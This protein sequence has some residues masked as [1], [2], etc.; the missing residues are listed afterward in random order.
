MAASYNRDQIR[1]ALGETDPNFSNY[2]DLETGEVVRLNDTD[3]SPAT[4]EL[5]NQIMEGY[6]DRY[7]YIPGGK[8][9]PSEPEINEW[10][11][12]EGI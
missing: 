12:A 6:G 7:R 4:E 1:V 11:E 3:T 2:L 10:L 5:R 8:S 9:G